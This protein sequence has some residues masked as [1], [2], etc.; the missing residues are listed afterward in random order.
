MVPN[1][2]TASRMAAAFSEA[3]CVKMRLA[4]SASDRTALFW[5]WTWCAVCPWNGTR[6]V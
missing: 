6:H 1:H 4:Y 2:F 3:A 5:V